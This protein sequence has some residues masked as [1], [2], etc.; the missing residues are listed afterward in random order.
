M[1]QDK[2]LLDLKQFLELQINSEGFHFVQVALDFYASCIDTVARD[3]L[4]MN[5]MY[6]YI[7]DIALPV[8]PG[9]FSGGDTRV[10]W[11]ETVGKIRRTLNL[12]LLLCVNVE[13]DAYDVTKNMIF[14]APPQYLSPLPLPVIKEFDIIYFKPGFFGRIAQ[15][16]SAF[17]LVVFIIKLILKDNSVDVREEDVKQAADIIVDIENFINNVM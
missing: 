13:L 5:V 4:G 7:K 16:K 10:N 17:E 1:L 9:F 14:I 8:I 11:T 6:K 2:S 12:D 3:E 15:K